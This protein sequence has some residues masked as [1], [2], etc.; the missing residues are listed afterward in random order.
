[1]Q[2]GK[3][4]DGPAEW[5]NDQGGKTA[6]RRCRRRVG[7]MVFY[8]S[9]ASRRVSFLIDLPADGQKQRMRSSDAQEKAKS[10]EMR[11]LRK[12]PVTSARL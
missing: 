3:F 5:A 11:N 6:A 7:D 2:N 8:I 12:S 10:V 1:M 9:G 4:A